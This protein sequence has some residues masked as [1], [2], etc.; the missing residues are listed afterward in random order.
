MKKCDFNK[1]VALQKFLHKPAFLRM[2]TSLDGIK[3]KVITMVLTSVTLV[4]IYCDCFH[5]QK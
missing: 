5:Y 1:V 2:S 4:L 3:I